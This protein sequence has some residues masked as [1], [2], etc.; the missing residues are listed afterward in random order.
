MNITDKLSG[1]NLPQVQSL[2][3]RLLKK[4]M[5]EN[6]SLNDYSP[7]FRVVEFGDYF[8]VI[9]EW[10]PGKLKQPADPT[11]ALDDI[12][13]VDGYFR[14]LKS[15]SKRKLVRDFNDSIE[16]IIKEPFNEEMEA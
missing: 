8:K 1:Y 15:E 2:V 3:S 10:F 14:I 16:E 11:E 6:K 9:Y 7:S 12:E 4:A 5:K 13:P